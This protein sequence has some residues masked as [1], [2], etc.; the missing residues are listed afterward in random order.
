MIQA[1]ILVLSG[2]AAFLATRGTPA[3]LAWGCA[4]GLLGQPFW[5]VSSWRNRQWGIFVLSL[6]YLW[7]W[8]SGLWLAV[9]R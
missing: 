6:W 9:G 7:S 2:A 8:G 5:L 4:L 1:A 3:A